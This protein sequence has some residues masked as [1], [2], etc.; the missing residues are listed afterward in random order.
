LTYKAGIRGRFKALH[1][2]QTLSRCDI[3]I[4][5]RDEGEFQGTQVVLPGSIENFLMRGTGWRL[6]VGLH[7]QER[8]VNEGI[9]REH[10]ENCFRG[11]HDT[12]FSEVNHLWP[13]A[14]AWVISIN[15]R[16]SVSVAHF[17]QGFEKRSGENRVNT[18]QHIFPFA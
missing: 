17:V 7:S 1:Y 5:P 8:I 4:L 14:E 2:K 11:A 3:E 15:Y 13:S 12:Y 9:Q 6:V 16:N 10:T 18:L